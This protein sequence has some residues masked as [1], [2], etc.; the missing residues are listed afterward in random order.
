MLINNSK[1]AAHADNIVT[2]HSE[3]YTPVEVK[4]ISQSPKVGGGV[5]GVVVT[6]AK[7][8]GL[9]DVAEY[10]QLLDKIRIFSVGILCAAMCAMVLFYNNIYFWLSQLITIMSRFGVLKSHVSLNGVQAP[11]L[12]N[13]R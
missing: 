8:N 11:W 7:V 6:S 10:A 12:F 13:K 5:Q 1:V 3:N 2:A 9:I 4:A